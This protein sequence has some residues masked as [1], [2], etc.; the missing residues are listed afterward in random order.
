MTSL[1]TSDSSRRRDGDRRDGGDV[2]DHCPHRLACAKCAFYRPK[3]SS[4]AQRLEA[5]ANLL[6]LKQEIP[7]T[8][9]EAA[10]VNDGLEALGR[11]CAQLA[12]VPAPAGPTPRDLRASVNIRLPTIPPTEGGLRWKEPQ[13]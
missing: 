12:D 9:E 4:Q 2:F 6:H 5:K 13:E 8:E 7:L 3:G 1:S 10:A 11:L